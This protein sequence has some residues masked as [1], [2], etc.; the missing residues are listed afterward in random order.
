MRL[1]VFPLI[2][3]LLCRLCGLSDTWCLFVCIM[4]ALPTAANAV[5][6]AEM[7][8]IRPDAAA[9]TV[10]MTAVLSMLT[11]VPI[12][13]FASDLLSHIPRER[14]MLQKNNRCMRT[15]AVRMFQ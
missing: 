2:V 12:T 9:K 7:Y 10:G 8:D 5:M 15:N 11:I 3:A 14:H 1:L 6:F 4:T 13:A